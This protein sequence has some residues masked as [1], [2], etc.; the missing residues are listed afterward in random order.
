MRKL[1]LLSAVFLAG[2]VTCCASAQRAPMTTPASSPQSATDLAG[3]WQ[4]TLKLPQTSLR[5]V[6]RFSKSDP[7]NDKGLAVR[8]FS[9]DQPTAPP[10]NGSSASQD[11]ASVKFAIELIGGTYAGT[12]NAEGNV[13]AG[14]WTQGGLP[15][16][17]LNL[18]RATKETAW[19]IPAPPVPAKP[20]AADADPT[21]DVA[22]I[23]PSGPSI[24]SMQ[25]LV[26]SGRNFKTK[27]SSLG[28]LLSFA[29]NVQTKQIVGAPD[30]LNKIA[31]TWTPCRMWRARRT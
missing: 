4:G 1:V 6:V 9:I 22:T 10:L 17:P 11:G 2:S 16:M 15:A 14:T 31:T 23:K 18:V 27:G 21:F 25:R 28:D 5:L 12:L 30:W 8:F 29:Y 7:K 13:I 20:M 3:D 26:I 19:E 24:N